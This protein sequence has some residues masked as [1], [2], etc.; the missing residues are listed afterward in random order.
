MSESQLLAKN[1][2]RVILLYFLVHLENDFGIAS[3]VT[4]HARATCTSAG[5]IRKN[6]YFFK[7]E[8]PWFKFFAFL[9]EVAGQ[10]VH[11]DERTRKTPRA[12]LVDVRTDRTSVTMD[13]ASL[14]K[15]S[16]ANFQTPQG[17]A[18]SR[19]GP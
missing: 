13:D 12:F 18:P 16:S 1:C 4:T 5:E 14:A 9:Y 2:H 6:S 8:V 10:S 17:L 3:I 15:P 11:A 7:F 19:Y